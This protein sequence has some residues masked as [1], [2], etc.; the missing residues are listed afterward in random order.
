MVVN[1]LDALREKYE[2]CNTIAFADLSTQMI[3]VTD[4]GSNRRREVL[5]DLCAEASLLLGANGKLA[6]GLKQSNSALV[7]SKSSV[8]M[9]LRA[10]DEPNDVL[11]CIC[12]PTVDAG[13]FLADARAC[14]DRISSAA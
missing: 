13:A 6:I 12:A 4:S 11:C 5:D 9:F 14:I 2:S 8:R 1:E 10:E 7:A 3:L